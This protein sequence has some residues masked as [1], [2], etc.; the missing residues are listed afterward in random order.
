L[1]EMKKLI[2]H[3][4]EYLSKNSQFHFAIYRYADSSILMQLIQLLWTRI[5]PYLSLIVAK[6]GDF[7]FSMQ[8]HQ[9]MAEAFAEKNK[10]ALEKALRQDLEL[11][12]NFIIPFLR[13]ASN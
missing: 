7:S 8:S 1:A 10:T 4:K 2:N 9:A 12:A 11:A 6:G 13:D 5:G 3:P